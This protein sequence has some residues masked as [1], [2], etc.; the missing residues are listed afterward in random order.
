MSLDENF[1]NA[2]TMPC[3]AE[4]IGAVPDAFGLLFSPF[5]RIN[6]QILTF[7]AFFSCIRMYS[8]VVSRRPLLI[9]RYI[10]RAMLEK[11]LGGLGFLTS[12]SGDFL[13]PCLN[14]A[15]SETLYLA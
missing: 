1:F 10:P 3:V 11:S 2:F 5:K 15:K 7:Y 12:F 9:L 13:C 4:S 8:D 6:T 14:S